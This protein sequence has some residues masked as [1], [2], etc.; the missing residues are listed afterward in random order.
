MQPWNQWNLK[1]KP[2]LNHAVCRKP[3]PQVIKL[4]SCST[5]LSMEFRLL[6]KSKIIKCWKIKI[7]LAFK[8]SDDVFI[9][10]I[11]VKMPII[12]GILTFMSMINFMLSWVEHDFFL[13]IKWKKA[14]DICIIWASTRENLSSGVWEQYRCRPACAPAQSAQ[15]L[16]FLLFGKYH[17]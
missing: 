8:L 4:F 13:K 1:H 16:C 3:G 7:F 11:N 17:M 12:V 9:M 5:Q 6:V 2:L 10:L 15:H 14:T